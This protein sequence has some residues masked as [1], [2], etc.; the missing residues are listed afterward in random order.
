MKSFVIKENNP[1]IGGSIDDIKID[2]NV[3]AFA[4]VIVLILIMYVISV[5]VLHTIEEESM[6]IGALFALGL[7]ERDLILTYTV[8]PVFMAWIG[9]LVGLIL[10]L[11]PIG[12]VV[13]IHEVMNYFSIPPVSIVLH[14]LI[15]IY[16]LALPPF[17]A[18][19]VNGWL[20]R[21]KLK[22]SPLS[23]LRKEQDI[24]EITNPKFI[25]SKSFVKTFQMKQ[26][27]KEKRSAFAVLGGIFISLL[28]L[29]IGINCLV[30]CENLRDQTIADAKF[31]YMYTYKYPPKTPPS[32]GEKAFV[33]TLKKEI[34]GYN[35]DVNIIGIK[36]DNPFFPKFHAKKTNEISV[37]KSMAQKYKIKVGDVIVLSD[38]NKDLDYGFHVK[39]IIPYSIGLTAF[40]DIDSMREVFQKED[41]YYNVIYAKEDLE[42]EG[43]RLYSIT[44]RKDLEHSANVFL[45]QMKPLI[46]TLTIAS[47]IILFIVM[48]Q[49]IRVMM[50]RATMDI[51]ML[52]IFGYNNKEIRK[53]YMDGNFYVVCIGALIC[54]P[55]ARKMI[56]SIYPYLISNVA[57]GMDFTFKPWIQPLIFLGIVVNYLLVRTILFRKIMKL[58]PNEVLKHRE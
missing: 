11:T 22:Q 18:F 48:A 39:E 21:K 2:F 50:E 7:K 14:P 19:I 25:R 33:H 24:S 35:M 20:I 53:L 3:G 46:I 29:Y 10:S 38:D 52:K 28:V 4:G 37:S 6:I 55:L 43:G 5:F 51:S 23:L 58:S 44:T 32:G 34:L 26:L 15:V 54:I 45:E 17:I 47:T 42:I 31:E 41:D 57:S 1:R 36:K 56:Q 12:M 49:M 8:L 40:M 16:A 13:Q 9:G 27:W 30:I